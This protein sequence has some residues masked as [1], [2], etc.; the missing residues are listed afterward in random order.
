[1]SQLSRRASVISVIELIVSVIE[2]DRIRIRP[3]HGPN[4]YRTVDRKMTGQGRVVLPSEALPDADLGYGMVVG[5]TD[6]IRPPDPI[7][8][9]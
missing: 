4:R 6:R 2:F 1:M 7:G 3:D 8:A 9:V 5:G